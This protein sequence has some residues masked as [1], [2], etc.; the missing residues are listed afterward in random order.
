MWL[1]I[2]YS[3]HIDDVN[4]SCVLKKRFPIV[5]FRFIC[6][7]I[8]TAP[9]YGVYISQ[10]IRY[11]TACASNHDFLVGGKLLDQEFLLV[12]LKSSPTKFYDCHH[13][14]VNCCGISLSQMTTDMFCL[15]QSQ[16]CP[17][18]IQDLSLG[19]TTFFCG[20]RFAQ[21]L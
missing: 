5:N 18:L 2:N 19:F 20:V 13:G 7:N 4:L 6:S 9:A 21:S 11:L 17:L 3:L 16:S 14:L 8:P 12:K 15:S 1:L 10:L